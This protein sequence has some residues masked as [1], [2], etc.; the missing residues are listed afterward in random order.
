M[1]KSEIVVDHAIGPWVCERT[2]GVYTPSD[3]IAMGRIQDGVLLGGVVFDHYNLASIA[4]H[5]AG[6]GA[7][8]TREF[9]RKAFA[10]PFDQLKVNKILGL[11]DSSNEAARRLDEHLGFVIEATVKDAAPH[12]DLLIYSMTREQCKY[13]GG[14]YGR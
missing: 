8:I 9:L 4:M 10:Y 14:R 12:G 11:V 13:L 1:A 6:D 7:W 3:S 2:G 5:C